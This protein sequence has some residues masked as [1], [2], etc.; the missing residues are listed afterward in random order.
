MR[1]RWA[2]NRAT[3]HGLIVCGSV[4]DDATG[5]LR[6]PVVRET[7]THLLVSRSRHVGNGDRTTSLALT[8]RS[9]RILLVLV[10]AEGDGQNEDDSGGY[11]DNGHDVCGA[12]AKCLIC[13]ISDAISL[14]RSLMAQITVVLPLLNADARGF[15]LVQVALR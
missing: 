3:Q 12:A 8:R 10:D 11:A 6:V 14:F 5:D 2:I 15:K 4:L 13:A 7:N 9:L 1:C